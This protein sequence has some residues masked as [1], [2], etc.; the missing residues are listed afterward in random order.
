MAGKGQGEKE[1]RGK[2]WILVRILAVLF[3]LAGVLMAAYPLIAS[4]V[5]SKSAESTVAAYDAGVSALTEGDLESLVAAAEEYNAALAYNASMYGIQTNLADAFTTES[6]VGTEEYYSLLASDEN[7]V[8]CYIDIPSI[9]VYYP[10][11]HGTSDAVLSAGIGHLA[12]SSLPVG[13]EN[14]HAVLT[15]HTGITTNRLFTDLDELSE[16]DLFYIHVLGKVLAYEVTE[17]QVVLP[18]ETEALKIREGEDLVTLVTCTPYGVNTH[19]LFVTGTRVEY[20][21]DAYDAEAAKYSVV[22]S[23][24]SDEYVR[25]LIAGLLIGSGLIIF[26]MSMRAIARKAKK[27]G[28]QGSLRAF[29]GI[30]MALAGVIMYF[31]PDISE[32]I[33]EKKTESSIGS[34]TSEYGT[35]DSYADAAES[36]EDI[37]SLLEGDELW[38]A[39]QS[40]NEAIFGNGQ[41][42][43]T[44][45]LAYEKSAIIPGIYD[46]FDEDG[47]FGYIE[48]PA[49]DVTLPLYLGATTEHMALGAAVMGVTSIPI[50]GE[51]TNSVIVGH[52]GYRGSPYFREIEKLAVGDYVYVTNPW[53]TL[54][55]K[56]VSTDII[57][58]SDDSAVKIQEGKDMITLLTCHPYRSH[59]KRRWVST[60]SVTR[61]RGTPCSRR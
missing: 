4:Y 41:E 8:M 3:A 28:A 52:R 19:R 45:A 38:E 55:Y 34:F 27:K 48:I 59:G 14:T 53:G 32:Y 24:I 25:A 21:G 43:L 29:L 31:Y 20:D 44:S 60:A 13:G 15:G 56:V 7:G 40:Y 17:I 51:N 39:C 1:G 10:V 57:S 16:G 22:S 26:L 12:G 47:V 9:G 23:L 6:L 46:G 5:N 49:M 2:R 35:E 11:F 50:G 18:S 54:A 30:L 37:S 33:L 36:G 58:P 42:G 61:K